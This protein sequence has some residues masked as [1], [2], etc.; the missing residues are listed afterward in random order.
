MKGNFFKMKSELAVFSFSVYFAYKFCI[1]YRRKEF[2]LCFSMTGVFI[3][4][5]YAVKIVQY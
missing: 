2:R 5:A 3:N 1:Q 4:I